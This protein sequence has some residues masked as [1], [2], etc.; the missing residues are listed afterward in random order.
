MNLNETAEV[1]KTLN[2]KLWNNKNILHDDVRQKL[3]EI[4]EEFVSTCE[5][6]CV[7]L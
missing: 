2:P 7:D 3:L 5:G 6:V 1:H 4:I